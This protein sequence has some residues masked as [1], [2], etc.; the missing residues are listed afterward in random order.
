MAV[1]IGQTIYHAAALPAANTK[2]GFEALTWVLVTGMID[3]PKFS[4]T[5]T[6]ASVDNLQTGFT[7]Q[8]KAGLAGVAT[9]MSADEILADAGQVAVKLAAHGKS[10]SSIK[11]VAGSGTDNA[12]VA[13]D[14]VEY[15]QG[16]L[17]DVDPNQGNATDSTVGFTVSF[18]QNAVTVTDVEPS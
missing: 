5:R 8:E 7:K 3:P 11:V 16:N 15:A 10:G 6:M 17:Y 13:G 12:P 18:T 2:A 9:T 14:P 4:T 1:H